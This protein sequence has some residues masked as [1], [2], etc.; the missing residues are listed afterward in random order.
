M[1][2]PEWKEKNDLERSQAVAA[3][4]RKVMQ[5]ALQTYDRGDERR[6]YAQRLRA[7]ENE[8]ES[9]IPVI[10]KQVEQVKTPHSDPCV[11]S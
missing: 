5:V 6:R 2:E 7:M 3:E 4:A 10:I 11:I 9:S 1:H 8:F